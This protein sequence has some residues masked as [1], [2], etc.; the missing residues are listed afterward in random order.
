MLHPLSRN[1]FSNLGK[2]PPSCIIILMRNCFIWK[3][4][5]FLRGKN[6]WIFITLLPLMPI[7]PKW[8]LLQIDFWPWKQ[9]LLWRRVFMGKKCRCPVCRSWFTTDPFTFCDNVLSCFWS[10][11]QWFVETLYWVSQI[12]WK[13]WATYL[14]KVGLY[15]VYLH[16]QTF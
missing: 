14:S 12:C 16:I 7:L 1:I 15:V 9:T 11:L 5:I 3:N 13:L 10:M 2:N 4:S 6:Y 8:T